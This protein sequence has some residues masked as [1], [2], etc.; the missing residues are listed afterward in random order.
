MGLWLASVKS[1]FQFGSKH[2]A[3]TWH[4][5]TVGGADEKADL[6][7]AMAAVRAFYAGV[8]P[9]MRPTTSHTFDGVVREVGAAEPT[10]RADLTTWTET[11][12]SGSGTDTPPHLAIVVSWQSAL[13]TRKGRGRTFLGPF[14]A[15]SLD[16]DGTPLDT[17][18]TAVRASATALRDASVTDNGWAIVVYSEADKVG[19]DVV[20]S[21]VTD[22]W[23]VMRSRRS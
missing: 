3:N 1:T 21:K 8:K 9:Y 23:A 17:T 12:T 14:G 20:N 4:I 6:N 19:R 18:L 10:A 11:G 7:A 15:A 2:G 13:A 22:Q 5:R 16:T